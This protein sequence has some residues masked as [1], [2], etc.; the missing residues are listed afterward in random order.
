MKIPPKK[1]HFF[2]PI[3]KGFKHDLK[4]PIGFLKYLK[5]EKHTEHAILRRGG[6]KC[7]VKLS[8]H[9]S[10]DG[11]GKF[12]EEND[13][14]LGDMLVFRHEGNM[15]FE[16]SIFDSTYCDREYAKT[17]PYSAA[18]QESFGHSHFECTTK[19][20]CFSHS[21]LCL[22]QKFAYANGI[23]NKKCCLIIRDERQ[24]S[25]DLKLSSCKTR[26]YIG[27]GWTKFSAD[28]CLKKG[29]HIMF[30]IVTNGETP[31]WKFQVVTDHEQTPLQKFQGDLLNAQIVTSTSGDDCHPCFISTIKSKCFSMAVLYFP[32]DFSKS[33]GLMN[34]KCEMILRDETERC[35]S[36]WLGRR[37]NNFR[38]TRG[39]EKFRAENGLQLG[40]TFKFEL[41][42]N[43]E[44]P[45]AH[46]HSYVKSPTVNLPLGLNFFALSQWTILT[47]C[48][49]FLH[50][51]NRSRIVYIYREQNYLADKLVK[52][53]MKLNIETH[54]LLFDR[55]PAD[56][57]QSPTSMM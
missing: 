15:E 28:N 48:G 25:W 35:W 37:G 11:W 45:I 1:P 18:H 6:K 55:T 7:L 10:E 57:Y 44:I 52:Y 39:W 42:K 16:V 9:R 50:P 14:K 46:F 26:T 8:G 2:K 31:I 19:G 13:V 34:R 21:Y 3:L 20:Y 40:D 30:E 17:S 22:P 54:L 41:I 56:L 23:T 36:M 4:I 27:G 51:L 49:Y 12:A 43:G 32:L 53:G 5:G 47:D 33:N 38:I 24:R 29:D